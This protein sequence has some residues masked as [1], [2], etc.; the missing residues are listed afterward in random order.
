MEGGNEKHMGGQGYLKSSLFPAGDPLIIL[1]N[2][3]PDNITS[4]KVL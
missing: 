2:A 1:F 3:L 4:I